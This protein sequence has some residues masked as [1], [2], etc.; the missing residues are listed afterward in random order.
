RATY[1]RFVDNLGGGNIFY[2]ANTQY[3]YIWYR[4]ADANGDHI[5]QRSEVNFNQVDYA[6]NINPACTSC[7][8]PNRIDADLKSP[9]TDEFTLTKRYSSRWSARLAFTWSDWTQS[10]GSGGIEDP[11]PALNNAVFGGVYGASNTGGQVV[12]SAGTGSGAKAN[13]WINSHWNLNLNGM[14]TLPLDFNI[15]GNLFMRQ[16]YPRLQLDAQTY[17]N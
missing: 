6:Y 7:K 1:G 15:A 13:V 5:A 4:W 10:L 3:G 8:N 2:N 12:F 16:G 11:T 17:C 14:Y 9:T